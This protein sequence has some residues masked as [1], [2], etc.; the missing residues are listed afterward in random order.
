MYARLVVNTTCIHS[1]Q[2]IK[3]TKRYR[4]YS[5]Y[6]KEVFGEKV[7]K[8]TI[9][10]GFSCPNRD[11]TISFGGCAF[12]DES[13]SF[14]QVHDSA[15]GVKEQVVTAIEYLPKRLGAKKF[16]A[17]FQAYSNTYKPVAELKKIYD[18]AYCDPRV[19]GISIGTRADC[20]D[21]E[22]LDLIKSYP[23]A[24][25]ELGLQSIHNSTLELI[26]R[27]HNYETFEKIYLK[28]K[29]RN[30]KVCVHII[31]GLEGE[32]REMMLESAK[33]LAS[34]NVDAIK[35]HSLTILKGAPIEK[36]Y[37][38]G[39]ISLLEEED[40]AELVCDFLELLPKETIIQRLAGSGLC[41]SLVAPRWVTN[42]FKT[43]NLIDAKLEKRKSFQGE[44][45]ESD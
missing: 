4:T 29:Q 17:Y 30:I 25:L 9:D 36:K 15:L 32:T 35:L 19:V 26:N 10:A 12:C 14:S 18:A 22:K 39:K 37:N 45:C 33:K 38:E 31:L 21:D 41:D 3:L 23:F 16:L 1:S 24:W 27:G 2:Q 5:E 42:R 11:G 6:L 40:Y 28:A 8:I 43:L 13:G 20:L 44:F 7:Y 34:L